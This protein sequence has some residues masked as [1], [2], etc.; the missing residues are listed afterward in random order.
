M[1]S[2]RLSALILV[3]SLSLCSCGGG[4]GSGGDGSDAPDT[5]DSQA[6]FLRE[7]S[8]TYTFHETVEVLAGS[9]KATDERTK[10][11]S[12]EHVDEIPAEYG[13]FSAYPGP[14]R[15]ETVSVDGSISLVTYTDVSGRVMVSDDMT[16][17]S[18]IMDSTSTGDDITRVVLGRTYRTTSSER[19]FDSSTGEEMGWSDT[20]STFTPVAIE[21]VTVAGRTRR[22]L[23]ASISYTVGVSGGT[24]A[25]TTR[26]TGEQWFCEGLGLV[27]GT[28][29]YQASSGGITLTYTVT[30]ELAQV[31]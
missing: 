7:P 2:A 21:N 18:R 6:Y 20:S 1:N 15:K 25:S 27:R 28:L 3:I 5:I 11:F 26:Y 23:K 12:Y 29:T 17:F 16:A 19:L 31:E 9:Q 22:A 30:D 14:F 10:V 24:Q 4:G 13:D 8:D